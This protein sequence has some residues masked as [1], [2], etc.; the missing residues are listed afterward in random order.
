MNLVDFLCTMRHN[1]DRI[2]CQSEGNKM[3]V[4]ENLEPKRVWHNFE[5]FCKVPHGTF[6]MDKISAYCYNWAKDLG[7]EAYQDEVKNVIIKK[8]GTAGYEDSEPVILQGHMDMVCEKVPGSAHD[9]KNDGLQL[10]VEDGCV[11]AKD[12]SLGADNGIAIAMAMALLES[13]DIPHPPLEVL[14]T[15]DEEEGM[16]GADAVDMSQFKGTKLINMDSEDEGIFTVGCAG[17]I[18]YASHISVVRE[19]ATGTKLTIKLGGL[20]GGHSGHVIG[21]ERGNANKMMGRFFNN[22]QKEA[23][24]VIVS[25]NGGSKMNVITSECVAEIITDDAAKVKEVLVG[26]EQIWVDEFLGIEPDFFVEVKEEE[27][28]TASALDKDSTSRVISYVELAPHGVIEYSRVLANTVETSLNIGVLETTEDEVVAKFQI[29][30]SMETMKWEVAHRIDKLN[31]LVGAKE[32]I[33]AAYPAW[34]YKPES[35]L[36]EIMASSYKELTG[37]DA[38]II[39]IHAGLECGYFMDKKPELDIVSCGPNMRGIHSFNEKLNIESTQRTWELVL[40][41]LAKCK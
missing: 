20:K 27:G 36:R 31:N 2:K 34:K 41:V 18:N 16:G 5:E 6:D 11:R 26:M 39:V 12:T 4:L 32:E 8:P 10:Y 7:L 25:V 9:F 15:V 13:K 33:I 1:D 14:F 21:E 29:R 40:D 37:K 24:F 23:E 3:A 35:E 30:S 28:V 22:L 19:D 17:G 38:D